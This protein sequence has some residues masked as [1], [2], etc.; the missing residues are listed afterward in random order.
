MGLT[1]VYRMFT[2]NKIMGRSGTRV[3]V[4]PCGVGLLF[5]K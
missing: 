5:K 2:V 3:K 4:G 1:I